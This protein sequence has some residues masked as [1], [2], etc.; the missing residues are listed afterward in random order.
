[1][2]RSRD[3]DADKARIVR[4]FFD[5]TDTLSR[6]S[7]AKMAAHARRRL[8]ALHDEARQLAEPEFAE[9]FETARRQFLALLP[10]ADV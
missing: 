4:A 5:V 6:T 10:G 3:V 2:R 7:D 1:M 9:S 8:E